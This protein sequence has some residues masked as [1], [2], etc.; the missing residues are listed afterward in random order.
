M[1]SKYPIWQ[2]EEKWKLTIDN[3]MKIKF[4]EVK[5]Y[6]KLQN[7]KKKEQEDLEDSK[8]GNAKNKNDDS[9]EILSKKTFSVSAANILSQF[10]VYFISYHVETEK[11]LQ[12]IREYGIAYQIEDQKLFEMQLELKIHLPNINSQIS[13]LGSYVFK[14]EKETKKYGENIKAIFIKR[15][16]PYIGDLVLLRSILL[17][18][19]NYF[20]VLKTD[21]FR[22][23]LLQLNVQMNLQTRTKIW[24]Q[25]LNIV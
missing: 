23:I 17:I 1:L 20:K 18:N 10:V 8:K 15:S 13:G 21:I 25:I 4:N 11:A 22:H 2:D 9:A 19:K 16:L 12:I 24:G 14:H 3:A 6:E 5:E 7:K